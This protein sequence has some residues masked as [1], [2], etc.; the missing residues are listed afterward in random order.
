MTKIDIFFKKPPD[1]GAGPGDTRSILYL[2]RRDLRDLS[3]PETR[4]PT[5]QDSLKAPVLASAGIIIGF[6]ILGRV[7]TGENDPGQSKLINALSE[8][9]LIN[10]E[11]AKTI[12]HFRN[13]L[14][15]GY[16][17]ELH[18]RDTNVYKFRLIS[19]ICNRS[20]FKSINENGVTEYEICFWELRS[21]FISA[22]NMVYKKTKTNDRQKSNFMRVLPFLSP[23]KM[24]FN[25]KQPG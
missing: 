25:S 22:V 9:L 5:S 20:F 23:Y 13:S 11:T 14:A 10:K 18:A 15:H 24:T 1:T 17:L 4:A 16:Q 8:I 19:D 3:C 12:M 21:K 7:W 6:E 2:L